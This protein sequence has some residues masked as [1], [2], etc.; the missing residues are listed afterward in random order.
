MRACRAR[1]VC[2]YLRCFGFSTWV[3][4]GARARY[5]KA[6]VSLVSFVLRGTYEIL[7]T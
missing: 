5:K 3:L 4:S 7:A 1:T 6:A 2:V